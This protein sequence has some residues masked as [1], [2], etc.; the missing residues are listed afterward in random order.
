MK[1]QVNSVLVL[2][3]VESVATLI[4]KNSVIEIN[5][6]GFLNQAFIDIIPLRKAVDNSSINK[7]PV[8]VLCYSYDII[9]D[10]MYLKGDR[11]LNY[12]DLI[13]STTRI[14]QRIDDPRFFKI[15]NI[16][17]YNIIE[18]IMNFSDIMSEIYFYIQKFW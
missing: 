5:Q 1:I 12:D 2:A 4:P 10:G 14:S 13:R 15:F 6:A 7:N 9:C 3:E 17:L 11:G 18:I 16:C 8:S